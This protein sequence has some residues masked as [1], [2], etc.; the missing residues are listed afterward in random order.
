LIPIVVQDACG[1]GDPEAA[2][3]ALANLAFMGDAIMTDAAT[4]CAT[5]AGKIAAW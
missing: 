5:V 3:R 2:Q 1:A 4:F